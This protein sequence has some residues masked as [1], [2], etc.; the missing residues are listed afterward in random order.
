MD[1]SFVFIISSERFQS[2]QISHVFSEPLMTIH[3]S[4]STAQMRD[5]E[6]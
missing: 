1:R 2:L 6:L 4:S 5:Y 3:R